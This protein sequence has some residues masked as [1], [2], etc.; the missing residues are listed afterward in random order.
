M[1][2]RG[3][4]ALGQ[5]LRHLA[6]EARVDGAVLAPREPQLLARLVAEDDVLLRNPQALEVPAQE[7]R[8]HAVAGRGEFA[9][10]G[11]IVDCFPP[12]AELPVRIE[13]FGDEIESVQEFDPLT[14]EKTAALDGIRAAFGFS[15]AE[16]LAYFER[17][18]DAQ[19][20]MLGLNDI[21]WISGVIF[22]VIVPL[23]WLAKP[24]KGTGGGAVA[25]H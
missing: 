21:F 11:G 25:A 8:H 23:I 6:G 4:F 5:R 24:V 1:G 19:A 2:D 15:P 7:G 14:G 3:P 20:S 16:A 18:L 10:R 12:S 17:G 13:F 22:L 9:R